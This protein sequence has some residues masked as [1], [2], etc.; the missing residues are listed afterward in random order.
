M[1]QSSR[2]PC[3][4]IG[5]S[6]ANGSFWE[7]DEHAYGAGE[8]ARGATVWRGRAPTELINFLS[9]GSMSLS[10]LFFLCLALPLLAAGTQIIFFMVDAKGQQGGSVLTTV[11]LSGDSSC[12]N[13]Q[14]PSSTVAPS[15]TSTPSALHGFA[16]VWQ[17][18]SVTDE[19]SVTDTFQT[20][21]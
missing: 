4:S 20:P 10:I 5:S 14:S 8:S 3:K 9:L 11:Q 16:S 15:S 1:V 21:L 7:G 6:K 18:N 2:P 19:V 17:G 13:D 12:I